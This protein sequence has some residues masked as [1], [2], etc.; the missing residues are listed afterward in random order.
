MDSS[1][2]QLARRLR[3]S[4]A[5]VRQALGVGVLLLTGWTLHG[6]ANGQRVTIVGRLL[7]TEAEANAGKYHLT[8]EGS[9]PI[10]VD[11]ES[12]LNMY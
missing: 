3:Y 8:D 10:C 9:T 11:P 4:R 6:Y 1:A 2:T 5:M 7:A 12:Y